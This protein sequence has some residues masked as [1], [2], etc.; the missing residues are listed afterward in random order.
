MKL[1][2]YNTEEE[3]IKGLADFFVKTVNH[4]I[5]TKDE[6]SVVLS[7]GNSPKKLHQLL[8]SDNYKNKIDYP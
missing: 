3:V 5:K 2:V 7:G 8:A 6:C 1:H 4:T